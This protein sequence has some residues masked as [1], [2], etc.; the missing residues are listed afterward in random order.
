MAV[1]LPG[2][3]TQGWFCSSENGAPPSVLIRR[4]GASG[5]GSGRPWAT[6]GWAVERAAQAKRRT[7]AAR[8]QSKQWAVEGCGPNWFFLLFFIQSTV[9]IDF[10][11]VFW[12]I[13]H[14]FF[15][16]NYSNEN[17]FRE[18]KSDR[19]FSEVFKS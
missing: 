6:K 10:C 16:S 12:K 18:F 8:V 11:S 19:N 17:L 5:A 13:S 15:Y 14:S 2:E 7:R 1:G 3:V 4:L 9:L